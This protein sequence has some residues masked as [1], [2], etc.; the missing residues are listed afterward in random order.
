[1]A[2]DHVGRPHGRQVAASRSCPKSIAQR[3][4]LGRLVSLR[5]SAIGMLRRDEAAWDVL[6]H[7]R[8]RCQSKFGATFSRPIA[9]GGE[10]AR[11]S[12]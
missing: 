10:T 4:R 5:N 12:H 8:R 3:P 6:P 11:V 7:S 1:M 2:T 9:N